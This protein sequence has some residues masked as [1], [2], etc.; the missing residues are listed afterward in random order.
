MYTWQMPAGPERRA[1]ELAQAEAAFRAADTDPH[2]MYWAG[3][4]Y[5][6]ECY[7]L[8]EEARLAQALAIRGS[9]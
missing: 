6:H 7:R 4:L 8:L 3:S 1:A 9:R 2:R 5:A